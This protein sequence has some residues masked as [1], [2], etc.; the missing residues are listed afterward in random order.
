M[1]FNV[2]FNLNFRKTSDNFKSFSSLSIEIFVIN[3]FCL[4]AYIYI[5]L[6]SSIGFGDSKRITVIFFAQFT[7]FFSSAQPTGSGCQEIILVRV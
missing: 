6:L 2:P 1:V 4:L 5:F 3:Y 7:L